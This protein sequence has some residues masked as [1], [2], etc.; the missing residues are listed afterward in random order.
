MLAAFPIVTLRRLN[1]RFID[2]IEQTAIMR[3]R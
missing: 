2:A 1:E 3:K